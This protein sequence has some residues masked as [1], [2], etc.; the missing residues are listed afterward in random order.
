MRARGKGRP[1]WKNHGFTRQIAYAYKAVLF[2]ALTH[3]RVYLTDIP[4]RPRCILCGVLYLLA[5]DGIAVENKPCSRFSTEDTDIVSRFL[6]LFARDSIDFASSF[7]SLACR[8]VGPDYTFHQQ[9][10]IS[11][12]S[13]DTRR[14]NT[15]ISFGWKEF[16]CRYYRRH[17]FYFLRPLSFST[18][19][20]FSLP[21][22]AQMHRGKSF[23]L[24]AR[25]RP[26]CLHL[27]CFGLN[28]SCASIC[29]L[30]A[31]S[32]SSSPLCSLVRD[33]N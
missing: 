13:A 17:S 22:V 24:K 1:P 4:I 29:R 14:D 26:S 9:H 12:D 11:R 33:V 31:S 8:N 30:L 27:N 21:R 5:A 7:S 19:T 23:Y 2:R 20:P 16:C 18:T 6:L 28:R 32:F 15:A 25:R 3:R 10:S